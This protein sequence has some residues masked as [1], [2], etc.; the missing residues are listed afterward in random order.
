[1]KAEETH[2]SKKL[3]D[4]KLALGG[5]LTIKLSETSHLVFRNY[6]DVTGI[7]FP[8]ALSL[9]LSLSSIIVLRQLY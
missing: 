5:L 9:S 8:V 6:N 1:M 3:W 7:G 4:C 2:L